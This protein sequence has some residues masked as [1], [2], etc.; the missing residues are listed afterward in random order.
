MTS[1][2]IVDPTE[3]PQTARLL[4]ENPHMEEEALALLSS[5]MDKSRCYLEYGVG[6]STRWALEKS[7]PEI[8][9]VESDSK[10]SAAVSEAA[11]AEYNDTKITIVNCNIGKTGHWGVP[12]GKEMSHKWPEYPLSVWEFLNSAG[13]TPDLI[14]IDG[15]FRA[16][17]FLASIIHAK[18]GSIILFDDF[19]DRLKYY[20]FVTRFLEI[21]RVIGRMAVF[22]TR[23]IEISADLAFELSRNCMQYR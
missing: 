20:E 16:A 8:V 15:R 18:P 7:I 1:D 11:K 2:V 19:M 17:C 9:C 5:E 21:D 3:H 14:L 23:Q 6:G 10:F 13:M 4:P 22:K 12:L